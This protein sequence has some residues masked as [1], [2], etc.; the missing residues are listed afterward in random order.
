MKDSALHHPLKTLVRGDPDVL[1][2]WLKNKAAH[3]SLGP[4]VAAIISG[5]AAYGFAIGLWRAP[6]QGL[7][8]AVKMP[9]LI[10]LTLL[11]NGLI[12]GMLGLLLGSGLSFRQTLHA[13]LMSFAIFSLIV[14]SLSPIAIGVVLDAPSPGEPGTEAWYRTILLTHT[15]IIAFAGIVANHK[16]LRLIQVF[17]GDAATGWRTLIAWLAGNL[18]VGAQ[19][20]Y[21]LRPF[22]G[23]PDL[24]VQF[25]RPAPF[26][27]SFYESVTKLALASVPEGVLGSLFVW[28]CLLLTCWAFT[29]A[30]FC[31]GRHFT[32]RK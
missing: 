24:P 23:N 8:V 13:C 2:G 28:I 20:S 27:G 6:I 22:F 17:S 29:R 31:F 26:D 21:N 19:L 16:L 1:S 3:Q 5:C 9:C 15:A 7:F 11:V 25:L 32:S 12:N 4:L 14:G 18:F 30:V 10:F